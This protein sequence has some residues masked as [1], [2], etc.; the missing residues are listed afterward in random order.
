MGS[1]ARLTGR[2]IASGCSIS[3][4]ECLKSKVEQSKCPRERRERKWCKACRYSAPCWRIREARIGIEQLCLQL[5]SIASK[6]LQ[7]GVCVSDTSRFRAD[8]LR[9]NSGAVDM[10]VSENKAKAESRSE[11]AARSMEGRRKQMQAP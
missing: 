11:S 6:L 4:Q 9:A 5:L 3:G 1:Q 2:M 10:V 8:P 7:L